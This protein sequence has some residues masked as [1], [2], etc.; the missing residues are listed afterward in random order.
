M[1]NHHR[2]M[3]ANDHPHSDATWPESQRV[4][5]EHGMWDRTSA[6]GSDRK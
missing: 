4:V 6:E 3:W 1:M 2:L 5:A